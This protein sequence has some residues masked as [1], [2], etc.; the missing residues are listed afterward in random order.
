MGF[1][2]VGRPISNAIPDGDDL[3]LAMSAARPNESSACGITRWRKTTSGWKSVQWIPVTPNDGSFEPT[4]IC[5]LDGGWLLGA[6][7]VK[8]RRYDIRL[9]RSA[10]RTHW[11]QTLHAHGAIPRAPVSINLAADRPYIASNLYEVFRGPFPPG[12]R[13]PRDADG[14]TWLGGLQRDKLCFWPVN[15]Q[16]NGLEAPIIVRDGSAEFGAAP[17]GMRWG[18]DHPS[19]AVCQLADGDWHSVMGMRVVDWAEV[20]TGADPTPSTGAYLEEVLS[21]GEPRPVWFF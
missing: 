13:W 17:G 14:R 8:G 9:W 12:V 21:D 15:Q 4:L 5:D 19:S 7:G 10:D 2:A 20:L 3:L 6:R 16:R 11:K 18:I 1:R